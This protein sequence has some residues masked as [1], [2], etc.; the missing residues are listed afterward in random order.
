MQ[1]DAVKL[2]ADAAKARSLLAAVSDPVT[3]ERLR[4]YA[5][6]CEAAAQRLA[7]EPAERSS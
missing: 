3:I 2:R 7:A 1:D 6:D 4:A 5:D